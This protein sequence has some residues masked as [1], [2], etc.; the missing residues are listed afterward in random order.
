M[1]WFYSYN[2]ETGEIRRFPFLR[3]VQMRRLNGFYSSYDNKFL[4]FPDEG[5]KIN[6]ASGKIF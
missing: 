2:L 4:A 3:G 1:S 5:G 6:I